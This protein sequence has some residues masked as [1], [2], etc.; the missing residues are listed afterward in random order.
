MAVSR[1]ASELAKLLSLVGDKDGVAFKIFYDRTAP[2]LFGVVFRIVANR[3]ETE[4][5][6][7]EVYM[8]VWQR[9]AEFDLARASPITWVA[10]IARNRS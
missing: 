2:M 5:I 7:Q 4:D 1:G 6:L 10:V 9:A 8:T 3:C